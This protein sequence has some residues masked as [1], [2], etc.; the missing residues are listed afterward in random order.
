MLALLLHRESDT[1]QVH[2]CNTVF[3]TIIDY[4]ENKVFADLDS[5]CSSWANTPMTMVAERVAIRI[6]IILF[7]KTD[8]QNRFTVK[9]DSQNGFAK[10]I[11][12]S[13]FA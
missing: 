13:L 4:K 3:V 12:D 1:T 2:Y 8:S 10:L 6:H 7:S 11:I 9:T 5:K